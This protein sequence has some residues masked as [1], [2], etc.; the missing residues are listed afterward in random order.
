MPRIADDEEVF[1]LAKIGKRIEKHHGCFQDIECAMDKDLEFPNNIFIVQS[2]PETVWG[3]RSKGPV[4]DKKSGLDLIVQK[5]LSFRG[6]SSRQSWLFFFYA[7]RAVGL[8]VRSFSLG[9]FTV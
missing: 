5:A 2:R 3:Q 8:V 7:S 1:E 4:A 6:K 9:N